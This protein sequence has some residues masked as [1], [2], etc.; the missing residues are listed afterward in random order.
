MATILSAGFGNKSK[1]YIWKLFREAIFSS[2]V[3][4]LTDF[5]IIKPPSDPDFSPV[6][7]NIL[8]NK[9]IMERVFFTFDHE[10]L[11]IILYLPILGNGVNQLREGRPSGKEDGGTLVKT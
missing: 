3:I 1:S 6:Y 10:K 11:L 9:S 2:K 8:C 7:V 4:N 5:G